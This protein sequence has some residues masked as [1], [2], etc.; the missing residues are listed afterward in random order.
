MRHTTRWTN[1]FTS[2]CSGCVPLPRVI[3][4][5]LDGTLLPASKQLTPRSRDVLA[6]VQTQG[7]T[8]VLATG[9]FL[10]LART[11]AAELGLPTP[12]IAL[13]GARIG[14][15]GDV[16]ERTMPREII[17]EILARHYEPDWPALADCGRDS[18]LLS[19]RRPDNLVAVTRAWANHS[20]LVDD[21]RPH[22][23]GDPG[24]LC[25]YAPRNALLEIAAAIE[26]TYPEL[27]VSVRTSG[28]ALGEA[29]ITLQR[30]G[31]SKGAALAELI[32]RLEVDRADVMAFGDWLNDLS[33]FEVAGTAVA[34]ANAV[35][36][37][38]DAADHVTEHDCDD[39][40]VARFLET[41]V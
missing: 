26:T 12:V 30:R 32:D 20:R 39:D 16:D 15:G 6:R 33:M 37:V 41:L 35:D 14:H 5:D 19:A 24:L 13:D 40:G 23:T 7:V 34:M 36:P 11:T 17:V 9:K 25:F 22:L 3:A 1:A 31:V 2:L 29:R 38:K 28:L 10:H 18:M 21:M 4:L 27:D 8:V